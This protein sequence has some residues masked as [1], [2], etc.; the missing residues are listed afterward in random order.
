[1]GEL[2]M[3]GRFFI[4]DTLASLPLFSQLP[5]FKEKYYRLANLTIFSLLNPLPHSVAMINF[6][7]DAFLSDSQILF[8]LSLEY[9]FLFWRWDLNRVLALLYD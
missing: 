7:P 9:F 2:D 5:G 6:H 8:R 4:L 1:M 3:M